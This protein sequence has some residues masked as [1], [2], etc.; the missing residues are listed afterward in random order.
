MFPRAFEI[1]RLIPYD[2]EE[3]RTAYQRRALS[4]IGERLFSFWAWSRDRRGEIRTIPTRWTLHD[5]LKPIADSF[6]RCTRI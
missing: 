3:Y 5:G 4:F 6:E 1:D 2:N